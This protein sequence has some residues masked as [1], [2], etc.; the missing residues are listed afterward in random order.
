MVYTVPHAKYSG[1]A[2]ATLDS[3][4]GN[5]INTLQLDASLTPDS[6]LQVIGSHSSAPLAIWS[7][8]GKLRVN[9]LGSKPV[10]SFSTEVLLSLC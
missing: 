10:T 5:I 8:N 7:E 4:T 6:D 3:V 1:I 9:I 2:V